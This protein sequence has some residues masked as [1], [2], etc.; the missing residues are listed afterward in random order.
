[1][2]GDAGAVEEGAIV[3]AKVANPPAAEGVAGEFGVAA[4]DGAG[5]EEDLSFT[6]AA[7]DEVLAGQ[8]MAGWGHVGGRRCRGRRPACRFPHE[9]CM[10][11][12]TLA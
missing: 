5:V 9:R 3:G 6:G 11:A 8:G 2:F 1:M 7:D 12:R 4:R 10:K